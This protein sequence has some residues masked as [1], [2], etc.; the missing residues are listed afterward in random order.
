MLEIHDANQ[1]IVCACATRYL[2]RV[3]V[4][5]V[6]RAPHARHE[7]WYRCVHVDWE[8]AYE[9]PCCDNVVARRRGTRHQQHWPW[10]GTYVRTVFVLFAAMQ[11]G[12]V[13][14]SLPPPAPSA[15]MKAGYAQ[16][17]DLHGLPCRHRSIVCASD[18]FHEPFVRFHV[19]LLR[20]NVE[21]IF[22]ILFLHVGVFAPV[23][24]LN[25]VR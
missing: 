7:P 16:D 12:C 2:C 24:R 20:T 13:R 23:T 1:H 22:A 18:V 4:K 19:A 3:E 14:A 5:W 15:S 9:E 6:F 21:S 8:I 10:E 25:P 11:V 17:R